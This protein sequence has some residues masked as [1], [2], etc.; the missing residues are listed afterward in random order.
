MEIIPF[1]STNPE[2]SE[3]DALMR[4]AE[5]I[6]SSSIV[7]R[8]YQGKPGNVF[9]AALMGRGFSWDVMTAMRCVT[10]IQGT[11][12]LKPEAQLALIR[13]RGHSVTIHVAED[14]QSVTVRGRRADTGDE[15]SASFSLDDAKRAGLLKNNT[16]QAYPTDMMTWR[17]VSRLS[18]QLFGDVVLGAGYAPEE[19]A[20]AKAQ[21]VAAVEVTRMGEIA[22]HSDDM[23][24]RSDAVAQLIAAARDDQMLA[25]DVWKTMG[26]PGKDA[27]YVDRSLL[28]QALVNA[29]EL[30]RQDAAL[31]DAEIVEDA[32]EDPF[33]MDIEDEEVAA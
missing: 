31:I 26:L 16:W 32:F 1:T 4:T 7:P 5:L 3:L 25:A 17:A 13:K 15:A 22:A 21:D 20:L 11:A 28:T 30:A 14:G 10:V 19:I 6:A 8:D 12:T 18:R 24:Q 27:K 9:A 29:A 33:A 23:V 2:A